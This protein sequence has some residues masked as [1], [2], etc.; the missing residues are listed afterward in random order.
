MPRIKLT[1]NAQ[2][3]A[4]ILGLG[5]GFGVGFLLPAPPIA[6]AA[7]VI[8]VIA[9]AALILEAI[10]AWVASRGSEGDLYFALYL[11][12]FITAAIGGVFLRMALELAL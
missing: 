12:V 9:L 11:A 10:L 5:I 3:A 1:P 7:F 4:Y 2:A 8:I 6:G